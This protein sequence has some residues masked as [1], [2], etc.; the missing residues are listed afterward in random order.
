MYPSATLAYAGMRS[1]PSS[2]ITS[3][4]MSGFSM[5][6]W[7]RCAYSSGAPSRPGKGIISARNLR[8]FSGSDASRGI[9]IFSKLARDGWLIAPRIS[10][11]LINNSSRHPSSFVRLR[12]RMKCVCTT[13]PDIRWC[14]WVSSWQ[15][16]VVVF[17]RGNGLKCLPD[18]KEIPR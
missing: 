8:T 17:A 5:M 2:R 13:I 10:W 15:W 9:H 4:L 6:N 14:H 11:S 18:K 3:P 16:T 7:T 12:I 1:A